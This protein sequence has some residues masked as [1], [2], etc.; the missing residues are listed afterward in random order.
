MTRSGHPDGAPRH[1]WRDR[2]TAGDVSHGEPPSCEGPRRPLPRAGGGRHDLV[3]IVGG[4]PQV[5]V[6]EDRGQ[7]ALEAA[8]RSSCDLPSGDRARGRVG[9]GVADR[10]IAARA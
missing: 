8:C 2:G 9:L 7:V 4:R 5:E 6:L 3:S 10:R 1:A